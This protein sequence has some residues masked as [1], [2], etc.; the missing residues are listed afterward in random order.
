MDEGLDQDGDDVPGCLG[1]CDDTDPT[2]APGQPELCDGVDNDC[3]GATDEGF[4]WDGDGFLIC[5][6]D[7]DDGQATIHPGAPEL[8]DGADTDCDGQLGSDEDDVD[9]DGAPLCLGDCDD[10]DPQ[11][12]PLLTELCDGLDND[13]DEVT[14][15]DEADEDGDGFAPCDGDCDDLLASRWPAASEGCDGLDSDC[16]GVVPPDELDGDGDGQLPCAGDCDDAD[17]AIWSGAP[18]LPNGV[19]DNC[20]GV[21]DNDPPTAL[22]AVPA[23]RETCSPV[24]LDGSGSFAPGVDPI[25]DY[26]W[27]VLGVPAGSAVDTSFVDDPWA[28]ST[29][30]V[31]DLPGW[32]AVELFVDAGPGGSD[33]S[34]ELFDVGLRPGNNPPVAA[35][36]LD[37]V[38]AEEVVCTVDAY[39]VPSCPACPSAVFT[40]DGTA[41]ADPDA[42][43]ISYFWGLSGSPASLSSTSD[44]APD[45]TVPAPVTT[46]GSTMTAT[47]VVSLFVTDCPGLTDVDTLTVESSCTGL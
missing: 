9:G 20:D 32:Y 26:T 35:A 42:D 2:V 34:T 17:S 5:A 23:P 28:V 22:I 10:E 19:D 36:G 30:F 14:P 24:V 41:S 27:S 16:D 21:V 44:P 40:L 15:A 4:D 38:V 8:C 11:R 31:P 33:A 45:L 46:Q 13:C 3:D 43:P 18:E 6:G 25:T 1:D 47:I 39:G 7:C 12:S 29:S 37:L